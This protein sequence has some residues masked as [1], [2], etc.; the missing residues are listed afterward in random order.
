MLAGKG[1]T[2]AQSH[3]LMYIMEHNGEPVF[4][5]AIHHDLNISRAT[6]SGLIKKLRAGGYLSYEG[7]DDDERHKKIIATEKA[8]TLQQDICD[9]LKKIETMAFRNFTDQE[10][11]EMERLPEKNDRQYNI[12]NKREE[13]SG[14]KE[15]LAQIKQYKKDS[16][17]TPVFTALE[18]FME[19]LL[20]FIMAKNNRRRH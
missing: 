18:V 2:A 3:V 7:S 14:L 10:L 11:D 13:G 15:I 8:Y 17:L 6:V 9:C 1:I 4:S 16:I 5:T 20:P 12:K 19:M